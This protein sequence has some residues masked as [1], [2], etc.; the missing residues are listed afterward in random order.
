[1]SAPSRTLQV[2]VAFSP[3]AREVIELEVELPAGASVQTAMALPAVHDAL[4]A[5]MAVPGRVEGLRADQY[6]VWGR[7]VSARHVLQDGDRIELYRPLL[8][9]PKVAR[10]E[11]FNRQGS[12]GTG[13]FARQRAGG[14]AGY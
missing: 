7:K 13:L 12:R 3:R 10:R 14:K 8:V 11:R 9:D 1:M 6:G 2:C 5:A 4:A